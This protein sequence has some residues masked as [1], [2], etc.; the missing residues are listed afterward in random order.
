[1]VRLPPINRPSPVVRSPVLSLLTLPVC[2]D[3]RRL[4]EVRQR[5]NHSSEFPRSPEESSD[6]TMGPENVRRPVRA[7]RA[8]CNVVI[9]LYLTKTFGCCLMRREFRDGRMRCGPDPP[10]A[11]LIAFS[12]RF[13][14]SVFTSSA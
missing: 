14:T 5:Q 3:G 4:V 10:R 7:K 9:S 11:S 13:P 8:S 2:K 6:A 1:M 12:F